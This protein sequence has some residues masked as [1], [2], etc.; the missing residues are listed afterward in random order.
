M[1]IHRLVVVGAAVLGPA[2]FAAAQ[3]LDTELVANVGPGALYATYAPGDDRHLFVAQQSGRIDVID[4][5]TDTV[6]PTPFLTV[7]DV[8]T[9]G[10]RGLLGL[11]FHPDYQTNGEFYVYASAQAVTPGQNHLSTVRR[12]TRSVDNPL[13]ADV[14]TQQ[15]VLTFDQPR[16]NHNAGWMDFG[17]N[18]G[19]LYIASGDGGPGDDPQSNA[20]DIT[21]NLL[22]GI[23][24]IDVNGDDFPVDPNRNYAIP[25]SNP[26]VDITGDDEIFA[27]G[28]RNPFRNSFDRDTGDLYIADVGQGQREEINVLPAISPGGENF[29]WRKWEGSRLNFAN[30]PAIP[31]A[32]F[33]D[34]EYNHGFG[35]FEGNSVTGGYVYRGPITQADGLYFFGD[36][37][38]NNI[39]TLDTNDGLAVD[40]VTA[41]LQ[42]DAGG[43]ISNITSFGEDLDGNLYIVTGGGS[44]YR[45]VLD[46][47]DGDYDG[48]GRVGQADL[49]LVLTHWGASAIPPQWVATDQFNGERVGQGELNGVL[50]NWGDGTPPEPQGSA[51][52][53]PTSL[54]LVGLGGWLCGG[55]VRRKR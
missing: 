48:D 21:D 15:T 12:F 3:N 18:D 31:D 33:P 45:L 28:L 8:L 36:F 17:P 52:P 42:P 35:T 46:L 54:A 32:V 5:T 2:S 44:V 29:G 43:S 1:S 25:S 11:A 9:G 47:I 37:I 20:Q 4:L 26:F 39:W 34:Y 10:E 7:P 30:D 27:Y 22:G 50:L 6:L 40:S 55:F 53:E 41:L 13:V 38:S 49:D 51:I 23:L 19:Y 16:S 14:G 24:R